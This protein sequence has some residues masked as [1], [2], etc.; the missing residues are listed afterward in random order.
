MQGSLS[1]QKAVISTPYNPTQQA[2]VARSNAICQLL[3]ILLPVVVLCA[4]VGHR[5]YQAMV[6]RWQIQRL[7]RIWQLDSSKKLS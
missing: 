7:N 5:K 3:V 2:S 4:I 6:L 1:I